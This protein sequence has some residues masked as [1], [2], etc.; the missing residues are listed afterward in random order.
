MIA[1]LR[2]YYE[3]LLAPYTDFLDRQHARLLT[4]LAGLNLLT[5]ATFA[6]VYFIYDLDGLS[7]EV[8]L[9]LILFPLPFMAGVLWFLERGRLNVARFTYLTYNILL[10]GLA[11]VAL[12]LLS[13]AAI[14]LPLNVILAAALL[15]RQAVV[16]GGLAVVAVILIALL[17]EATGLLPRHLLDDPGLASGLLTIGIVVL[18]S[19]LLLW[20]LSTQT[21]RVL[22]ANRQRIRHLDV[23]NA[24]TQRA[25]SG[26]DDPALLGD[27]VDLIQARLGHDHVQLF[28]LDDRRQNAVLVASTGEAGAQLLARDHQLPVGSRSVIGRVTELGQM[29]YAADTQRSAVHRRNEIL[30]ASRAEIAF[31][32]LSGG[33]VIGALDVQSN[34]ANAFGP[35]ETDTLDAVAQ[36]LSAALH[37]YRVLENAEKQTE[38][39]QR[40]LEEARQRLQ[41]VERTNRQLTRQAWEDFLIAG[42][43]ISGVRIEEGA[44][45]PAEW[46]AAL[47]QAVAQDRVVVLPDAGR[48]TVAVPLELRGNTLGALEVALPAEANLEDSRELIE[49]VASRLALALDNTRLFE[50]ASARAEQERQIGQIASQLQSTVEIEEMLK[51]AVQEL[52]SAVGASRGAIRLRSIADPAAQPADAAQAADA[53]QP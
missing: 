25:S 32:L 44:P 22:T 39:A 50:E 33:R 5:V 30:S 6:L 28:L 7:R 12:D 16:P 34:R 20:F 42:Q 31:P 46:T 21:D 41:E 1:A 24:V 38:Q 43:T 45:A 9:G 4:I 23:V 2:R 10:I 52:Q 35:E 15:G 18:I 37:G 26:L 48:T 27:L 49:A 3:R 19:V 40:Q 13:Y 29:V 47:Q 11:A 14:L 36:Q 17:A 51:I 8:S 53:A